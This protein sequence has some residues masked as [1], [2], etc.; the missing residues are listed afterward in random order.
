LSPADGALPPVLVLRGASGVGKSAAVRLVRRRIQEGATIEVD[1]LWAIRTPARWEDAEQHHVALVH[2]ALIAGD[3]VRRRVAPVLLVDHLPDEQW[4]ILRDALPAPAVLHTLW[5]S[6]EVLEER[7]TSRPRGGYHDVGRALAR[8]EALREARWPG[9]R[10][11]DTSTLG[12]AAVATWI[13]AGAPRR[14]SP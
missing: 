14:G 1:D 11:L 3:L 5:A 6:P 2:A 7:I 8:N 12:P 10:W 13:L 4:P 9:E